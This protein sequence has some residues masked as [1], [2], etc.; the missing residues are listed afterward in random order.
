MIFGKNLFRWELSCSR[1]T[2]RIALAGRKLRSRKVRD[3]ALCE[4][5]E[6]PLPLDP[7]D[8]DMTDKPDA[9]EAAR[10]IVAEEATGEI[11]GDPETLV[12]DAYIVA[13]EYLSQATR[14]EEL[15][16]QN[17]RLRFAVEKWLHSDYCIG[18]PM[19]RDTVRDIGRAAL[20]ESDMTEDTSE[21]QRRLEAMGEIPGERPDIAAAK[22]RVIAAASSPSPK[23]EMQ[24]GEMEQRLAQEAA[25]RIVERDGPAFLVPGKL[26]S[27]AVL[28]AE[29]YLSSSKRIE[30]LEKALGEFYGAERD[31]TK[32]ENE[33]PDNLDPTKVYKRIEKARKA[34]R[35]ALRAIAATKGE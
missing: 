12:A 33:T 28:V 34:A 15:E 2:A 9:G 5:S 7:K 11:T 19:Y 32:W 4:R 27:D 22:E 29:A 31:V 35:A 6:P 8:R 24:G 30:E 23:A 17:K 3:A 14:I 26:G 13:P 10:R 16:R 20:R 21:W 1:A 18:T 25:R